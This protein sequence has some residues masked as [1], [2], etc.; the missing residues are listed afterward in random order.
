MKLIKSDPSQPDESP[1][2]QTGKNFELGSEEAREA[3]R[4]AERRMFE[5][6]EVISKKLYEEHGPLM[7]Q[8]IS[9]CMNEWYRSK[10]RE[11]EN[12]RVDRDALYF[13]EPELP[14]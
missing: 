9:I 3:L 14:F 1:K 11:I 13:G 7:F 4:M 8:A 2:S 12:A 5:E 10:Y 6:A